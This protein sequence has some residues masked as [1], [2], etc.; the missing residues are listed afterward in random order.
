MEYT[1][2]EIWDL[3][4]G[5]RVENQGKIAPYGNHS[6]GLNLEEYCIAFHGTT[7]KLWIQVALDPAIGGEIIDWY[8]SEEEEDSWRV[9]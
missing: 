9:G 7:D 3:I 5:E 4:R 2:E 8:V 1:K 6:D